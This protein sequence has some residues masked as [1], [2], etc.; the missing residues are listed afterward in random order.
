[1]LDPSCS[2]HELGHVVAL[3]YY[4]HAWLWVAL[5]AVPGYG[6]WTCF[7]TDPIP[8]FERAVIAMAGSIA[9]ARYLR[10]EIAV[11]PGDREIAKDAL[12]GLPDVS[13][14]DGAAVVRT[15]TEIVNANWPMIERGARALLAAGRLS[16]DEVAKVLAAPAPGEWASLRWDGEPRSQR[17]F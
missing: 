16:C 5:D 4:G 3:N 10:R 11:A 9:Q 12:A 8:P 15:A 17:L 2:F 13:Q 1:M 14:F 7:E 6:G